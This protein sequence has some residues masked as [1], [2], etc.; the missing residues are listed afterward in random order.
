MPFMLDSQHSASKVSCCC[1]WHWVLPLHMERFLVD[2]CLVADRG[3]ETSFDHDS[4]GSLLNSSVVHGNSSAFPCWCHPPL[5]KTGSFLQVS[6]V[7]KS[8]SGTGLL[9]GRP[10]L[11]EK[12]PFPEWV[13]ELP[14]DPRKH[15]WDDP[16][17]AVT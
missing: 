13:S 11:E 15:T 12:E 7:I 4:S 8:K 9:P 6:Q 14:I 10:V 3:G 2:M 16:G 17:L 5:P 1:Q